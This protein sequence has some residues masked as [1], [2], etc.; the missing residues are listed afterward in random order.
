MNKEISHIISFLAAI[1]AII[2][3]AI[4]III[5][6]FVRVSIFASR[7]SFKSASFPDNHERAN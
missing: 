5:A 2:M 7:E 1:M 4:A 6:T 3:A